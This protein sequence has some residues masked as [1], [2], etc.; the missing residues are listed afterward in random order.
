[1]FFF[2][3]FILFFFI[4]FFYFIYLFIYLFFVLFFYVLFFFLIA[5]LAVN[6]KGLS[7]KVFK[8]GISG[9]K[10]NEFC[11]KVKVFD[12]NQFSHVMIYVGRNDASN[13]VDI[14]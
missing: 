12:L 3:D 8:N 1:M 11:N 5:T 13:S 7:Q 4:F 10:L 6:P 14:E 9:A 2:S